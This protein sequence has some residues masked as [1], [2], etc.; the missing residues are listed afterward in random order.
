[1]PMFSFVFDYYCFSNVIQAMPISYSG[2]IQSHKGERTQVDRK[3]ITD[4]VSNLAAPI[5]NYKREHK[6]K[7]TTGFS[8]YQQI[9]FIYRYNR[10]TVKVKGDGHA[11]KHAL[12]DCR[13]WIY[14]K[15]DT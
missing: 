4:V 3:Y 12:Q 14:G 1:M 15:S 2:S 13:G 10:D 7:E 5:Q 11:H 6:I 9:Q 8:H